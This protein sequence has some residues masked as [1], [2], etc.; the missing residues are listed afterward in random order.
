MSAVDR[1]KTIEAKKN[2]VQLLYDQI[3]VLSNDARKKTATNKIN[4]DS[5]TQDR[6]SRTRQTM[7]N[8]GTVNDRVLRPSDRGNDIRTYSKMDLDVWK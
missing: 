8:A 4:K 2:Q 3:A 6:L 5:H 1:K 7:H